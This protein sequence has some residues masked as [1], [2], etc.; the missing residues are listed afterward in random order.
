MRGVSIGYSLPISEEDPMSIG[1]SGVS[2]GCGAQARARL[3]GDGPRIPH[4]GPE[5]RWGMVAESAR[6]LAL[7]EELQANSDATTL[8]LV[9]EE[10]SGRETAAH[11]IHL[12]R[13]GDSADFV[14]IRSQNVAAA[15]LRGRVVSEVGHLG[16][17]ATLFIGDAHLLHPD[18]QTMLAAAVGRRCRLILSTLTDAPRLNPSLERLV[19]GRVVEI[20]ALRDRVD[21][22][23]PLVEHFLQGFCTRSCGCVWGLAPETVE[24]LQGHSWPGNIES[25]RV[26]VDHAVVNGTTGRIQPWDL[27]ADIAGASAAPPIA[28]ELGIPTLEEVEN[29]HIERALRLANGNKVKTARALGISRHKLYDKLRKMG[30][31]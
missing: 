18:A 17:G 5:L 12:M 22:V 29:Q 10:G 16:E 2:A 6:G 19:S 28:Q 15:R 13:G 27:P 9:G 8:L 7:V 11:A 14:S 26:A 23:E 3:M 1:R 24:V 25:L 30:I 31:S 21:D 4:V 20:P